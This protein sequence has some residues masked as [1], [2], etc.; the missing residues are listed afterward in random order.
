MQTG[1]DSVRYPVNRLAAALPEMSD[2]DFQAFKDDIRENGQRDPIAIL[3]GAIV[4]GRHRERALWE[5][6]IEPFYEILPTDTDPLKFILSKHRHR[7]NMSTSQS[8]IASA[9]IYLLSL[10][11]SQQDSDEGETKDSESAKLQIA[12]LTQAEAAALFGVKMRTFSDAVKL[13]AG[14]CAESLVMAVD[15]GH[16]AVSDAVK[17]IGQPHEV[18]EAAVKM[19][20]EGAA[21]TVKAAVNRILNEGSNRVENQESTGE[22]WRSSDGRAVLH[23]CGISSLIPLVEQGSVD[24][25]I[26]HVP[27]G[28][29]AGRTLIELRDFAAHAL[30][31][32]G[33]ATL[34][35][36]TVDLPVVFRHLP[37]KDIQFLCELDY[38]IDTPARPLGG[39]HAITLSR[40]PLL[41]FGKAKSALDEGDDVIQLPPLD[42]ASTEVRLGER[43]AVGA[44]M[45]VRRFTVSGGL[46]CDPLLL[47]GVNNGLAAVRNG[48]RFVG[49]CEDRAKFDYVRDRLG[50]EH[51]VL[52]KGRVS[53]Q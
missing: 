52:A 12:P 22:S 45:I 47:G 48:C 51:E 50:R 6:G 13:L 37:G 26:G 44:R 39:S 1:G 24:T 2:S 11:G 10:E 43:H 49:A 15:Q 41:V 25:I 53:E 3:D 28:D 27:Q 8:A 4:D 9:R 32:Y 7:R 42:D 34:L 23:S 17:V 31:E 33:L 36:R 40:M 18:Q 5:L 21:R 46:V 38:R 16:V 20:L 19:V 29:E 30:H 35:C 14:E